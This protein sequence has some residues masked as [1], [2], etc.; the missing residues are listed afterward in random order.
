MSVCRDLDGMSSPSM[1]PDSSVEVSSGDISGLRP[2]DDTPWQSSP[3]DNAPQVTI[4]FRD[5]DSP[6]SLGELS[7]PVDVTDNIGSVSL[8][9]QGPDDDTPQAYNPRDPSSG[10]PEVCHLW[11]YTLS[12]SFH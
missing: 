12:C 10:V 8:F 7:F 1:I 4:T 11:I 6:V 2:S 5:D 9:I 3:G